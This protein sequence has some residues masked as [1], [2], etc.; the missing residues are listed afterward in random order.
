MIQ[1]V[2]SCTQKLAIS[3]GPLVTIP[4]KIITEIPFP[5]PFS[6]ICSPIHI[7][8]AVPAVKESVIVINPIIPVSSSAPE[9][10]RLMYKPAAWMNAK[11]TV[12]YLVHLAIT[13]LPSSPSLDNLSRAGIATARSCM[14][15]DELT[16]GVMLIA[17]IEAFCIALPERIF[18]RLKSEPEASPMP[19]KLFNASF[20]IPGTGTTV[21]SW[22]TISMNNVNKS[23]FLK[24]G[25]LK[26]F[27]KVLNTLNHLCLSAGRL[28]LFFSGLRKSSCF[29]RDFL[30]DFTITQNYYTVFYLFNNA[31]FFK[32]FCCDFAAVFKLV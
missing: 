17:K 30:G 7:R 6:V 24:S 22:N 5:I 4:A 25:I 31:C 11:I 32:H 15:I 26:A 29:N 10:L 13:F 16:Y 12:P 1:F 21:P 18:T 28:D 2:W 14:M 27:T 23:F 19:S 9:L 8:N 20:S 3:C